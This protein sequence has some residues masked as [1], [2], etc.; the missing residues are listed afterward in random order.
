MLHNRKIYYVLTDACMY[1]LS[2]TDV[3]HLEA[4]A[5]IFAVPEEEISKR[6]FKG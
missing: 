6:S 3:F 5:K 2:C 1:V 4:S